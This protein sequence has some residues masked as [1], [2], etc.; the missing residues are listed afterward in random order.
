[1]EWSCGA[2]PCVH[3]GHNPNGRGLSSGPGKCRHNKGFVELRGMARGTHNS[4]CAAQCVRSTRSGARPAWQSR[5]GVAEVAVANPSEDHEQAAT[6]DWRAGAQPDTPYARRLR[7]AL[8]PEVLS[9]AAVFPQSSPRYD[10][11]A[12]PGDSLQGRMFKST[13]VAVAAA[14]AMASKNWGAAG[15]A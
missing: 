13:T 2:S 7:G 6:S 4:Q 5:G 9:S 1:M 11:H 12:P 8:V 14:V 15:R 10:S 3:S